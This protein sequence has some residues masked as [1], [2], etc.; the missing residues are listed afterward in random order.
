MWFISNVEPNSPL[1]KLEYLIPKEQFYQLRNSSFYFFWTENKLIS[2]EI[3][4]NLDQAKQKR[5]G[6]NSH[7]ILINQIAKTGF[8]LKP[9]KV[10]DKKK[11]K[12]RMEILSFLK[13]TIPQWEFSIKY[14]KDYTDTFLHQK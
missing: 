6:Y 4:V 14:P 5:F 7:S 10:S 1:K 3:M 2:R 8:G 13:Q 12:W 11:T 9:V